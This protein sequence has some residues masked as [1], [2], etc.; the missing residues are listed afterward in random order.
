MD[1][2]TS[3]PSPTLP[4]LGSGIGAVETGPA[5]MPTVS[6]I[7]E[8]IPQ[9]PKRRFNFG[10][11]GAIAALFVLLAGSGAAYLLTQQNQD[12]RN[13][14]FVAGGDEVI[15]GTTSVAGC[16]NSA[17]G[18]SCSSSSGQGI[19][20]VAVGDRCQCTVT[21]DGGVDD[22][23]TSPGEDNDEIAKGGN[24]EPCRD[25]SAQGGM[26]CNEGLFCVNGTCSASSSNMCGNINDGGGGTFTGQ[27]ALHIC[28]NQCNYGSAG[29]G[30]CRN[31]V[32]NGDCAALQAELGSRCGQVD[33]LNDGGAY[34]G[35]KSI[36]CSASCSPPTNPPSDPNTVSCTEI[37]GRIGIAKSGD[38]QALAPRIGDNFFLKC[39]KV[40]GASSYRFRYF[41]TKRSGAEAYT[42][43]LNKVPVKVGRNDEFPFISDNISVTRAGFYYGQCKVCMPDASSPTGQ[44]C[45]KWEPVTNTARRLPFQTEPELTNDADGGDGFAAGSIPGLRPVRDYFTDPAD[46]LEEQPGAGG[47]NVI[48]PVIGNPVGTE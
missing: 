10:M 32:K 38:T 4:P 25:P 46:L 17:I 6:V 36:N 1:P 42:S 29:Q 21:S 19:C 24:G 39:R 43:L 28:D 12:V 5:A 9:S 26:A 31:F 16:V 22:N 40:A 30:E 34:C 13:Q 37:V 48:D 27:C 20:Q 18:S 35:V 2:I 11:L 41:Y 47:D 33:F 7:P 14:A 23:E 3:T 15:C 45:G 8:N 44:K